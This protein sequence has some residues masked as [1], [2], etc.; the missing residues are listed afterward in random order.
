MGGQ[1]QERDQGRAAAAAQEE[2]QGPSGEQGAGELR[3]VRLPS[4]LQHRSSA[5]WLAAPLAAETEAHLQAQATPRG[6]R[7]GLPAV[8]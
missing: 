2:N 7:P 8:P 3:E 6:Q 1:G 5:C 4:A